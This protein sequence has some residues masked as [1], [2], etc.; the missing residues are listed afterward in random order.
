LRLLPL[1]PTHL[2]FL[3]MGQRFYTSK[4]TVKTQVAHRFVQP[5][6]GKPT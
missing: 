3:E 6:S 5:T 2:K 4:H 1:L